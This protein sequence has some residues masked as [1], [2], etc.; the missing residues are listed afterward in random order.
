MDAGARCREGAASARAASSTAGTSSTDVF[1][2]HPHGAVLHGHLPGH[3][4]AGQLGELGA[5]APRAA[6]TPR[7]WPAAPPCSRCRPTRSA[8]PAR[9]QRSS[10]ARRGHRR[11]PGRRSSGWPTSTHWNTSREVRL[12][13]IGLV[14]IRRPARELQR[15]AVGVG[16]DAA[17]RRPA[18]ARAAAPRSP[19][20]AAR[21]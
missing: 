16:R 18:A 17:A 14:G 3:R 4:A 10:R 21:A 20:G 6:A 11:A 1:V 5:S 2:A 9:R 13:E 7:G 19:K 15:A 12:P 8:P